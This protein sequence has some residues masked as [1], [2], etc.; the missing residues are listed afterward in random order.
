MK[1]HGRIYYVRDGTLSKKKKK[2]M[3]GTIF[4]W[5]HSTYIANLQQRKREKG[6]LVVVYNFVKCKLFRRTYFHL[7]REHVTF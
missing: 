3:D 4:L 1:R 2:K 7:K 6:N 5:L